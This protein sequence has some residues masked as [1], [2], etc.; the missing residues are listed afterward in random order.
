M[1]IIR[2]FGHPSLPALVMLHGFLGSKDDWSTLMPSLSQHFHCICIDLPGHGANTLALASPGFSQVAAHIVAKVSELGINQFHLLG[3][4]L[5]GRIALHIAQDFPNALLSLTLESAHPGLIDDIQRDARAKSDLLW[6]KKLQQLTITAF[7]SLW[8]Q[9]TVFNDLSKIHKQQ[10]IALR[11]NNN[12][13]RLNNCYLATS[14]SL[15]QDCRAVLN[16]LSCPCFYLYGE[17]DSKF[18]QVAKDWQAQYR[19]AKLIL[20]PLAAAGHNIHSLHPRL[21]SDTLLALLNPITSA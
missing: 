6:A 8:Y 2:R 10:L 16:Q 12:P 3:Y 17:D 7:L 20:Q 15:Q 13:Q 19:N 18:A 1:V 14:L 11:N 5:G 4:S 9:Q 21:F